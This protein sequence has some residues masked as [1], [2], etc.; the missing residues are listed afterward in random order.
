MDMGSIINQMAVLFLILAVGYFA[1][2]IGILNEDANKAVTRLVTNIVMPCLIFDSMLGSGLEISG[3]DAFTFLFLAAASF[4]I[5]LGVAFAAP[6]ILR[7][8]KKD[9]GVYRFLVAFSNVGFVGYPVSQAVFG[10]KSLFYVALYCIIFNLWCFSLGVAFLS[11]G[12]GKIDFKRVLLNPI[13]I[14]TGV[15]FVLFLLHVKLPT[16]ILDT[17]DTIGQIAVP[18]GML[19]VGSALGQIPV[20]SVFTEWRLYPA[21][22]LRLIVTPVLT[23]LLFS[24]FVEDKI[25]LGILTVMSSLPVATLCTLLSIQYGADDVLASKSVFISTVL[26]MVTIP[27]LIYVLLI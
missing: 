2:R 20:K 14:V 23:W 24:L 7:V 3:K 10:E 19:L 17:F 25:V 6:F 27:C 5:I 8:P 26:S 16:P 11:G 13:L 4:V 9:A 22:L 21:S 15:S 18:A 1:A 12:G